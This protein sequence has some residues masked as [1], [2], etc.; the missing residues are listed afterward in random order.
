MHKT[1]QMH[2]PRQTTEQHN[3]HMKTVTIRTEGFRKEGGVKVN[4]FDTLKEILASVGNDEG[5]VVGCINLYGQQ[6]DALPE[7]K[8]FLDAHIE[9]LGFKQVLK[10]SVTDKTPAGVTPPADAKNPK[11][12]SQSTYHARFCKAVATGAFKVT[13]VTP[14]GKDDA[15]KTQSVWDYLQ[16][17][18]D[19][20][21]AFSFDLNSAT[22]VSKTKKIPE[23]AANA[24]KQIIA[25]GSQKT[26]ATRFTDGYVD[27]QKVTHPAFAFADFQAVPPAGAT[28]DVV[29]AT[30]DTNFRNLAWAI[31]QDEENRKNATAASNYA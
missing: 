3:K 10:G 19:K 20:H 16:G 6:K 24:A 27:K 11:L 15:E 14:T 25:N 7:S 2:L 13:G 21:G 4:Q 12:E 1:R 23:F 22:R 17:V 30:A 18:L 28:P 8:D 26:W 31:V 9:S 5:K 29:A